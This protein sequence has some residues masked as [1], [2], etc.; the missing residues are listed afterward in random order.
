MV[1]REG[2]PVLMLPMLYLHP[3]MLQALLQVYP[4]PAEPQSSAFAVAGDRSL[5]LSACPEESVSHS[6]WKQCL[7]DAFA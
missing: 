5:D 7:C 1:T 3:S 2:L 6:V 4:W